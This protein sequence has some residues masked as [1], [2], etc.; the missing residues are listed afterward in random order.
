MWMVTTELVP[1]SV[2]FPSTGRGW[3]ISALVWLRAETSESFS[4]EKEDPCAWR[5]VDILQH[6]ETWSTE[7]IS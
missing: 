4:R 1:M 3:I 2:Q 6:A 7:T 5:Q